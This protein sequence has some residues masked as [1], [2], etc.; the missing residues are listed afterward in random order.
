[1]L[2]PARFTHM[3]QCAS[4]ALARLI[5]AQRLPTLLSRLKELDEEISAHAAPTKSSPA[6]ASQKSNYAALDIAKAE[7][8]VTAREKRLELLRKKQREEEEELWRQVEDGQDGPNLEGDHEGEERDEGQHDPRGADNENDSRV[9]ELPPRQ[10][11]PGEPV[12]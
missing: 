7:R 3:R 8:L 4:Q 6:A 12:E 11:A 1:M 9:A 2:G 5:T 10:S